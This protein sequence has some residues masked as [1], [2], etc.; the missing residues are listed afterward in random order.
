MPSLISKNTSIL[1]PILKNARHCLIHQAQTMVRRW[2]EDWERA[3]CQW[4]KFSKTVGFLPPENYSLEESFF[5]EENRFLRK[6]QCTLDALDGTLSGDFRIFSQKN[7]SP[8]ENI[9]PWTHA[10]HGCVD[11]WFSRIGSTRGY[12]F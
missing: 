6:E 2:H 3:L 12:R 10:S 5:S 11:T 8:Q 9:W 4:S 1:S 7:T